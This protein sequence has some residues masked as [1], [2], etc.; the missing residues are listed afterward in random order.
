MVGGLIQL[1]AFGA[2]D[3]YLIGNP[4]ITYFKSVYSRHTN[5]CIESISHSHDGN[6]DFGNSINFSID[7]SG[8]LVGKSYIEIDI[9][10]NNQ[11]IDCIHRFGHAIIDKVE[12]EIG[13]Q[14]IDTHYGEWLEIWSQMSSTDSQL[15]TLRKMICGGIKSDVNIYKLYIPLQFWFNRNPGLALP[16]IALQYHKVKIN[17]TFKSRNKLNLHD[18]LIIQDI[19]LYCDYIYLDT[20]ER[21]R[22]AQVNHEYLIEQVQLNRHSLDANNDKVNIPLILNHPCKELIWIIKPNITINNYKIGVNNVSG[23]FNTDDTGVNQNTI[24][25]SNTNILN[26][27]NNSTTINLQKSDIHQNNF[28]AIT[29]GNY[30]NTPFLFCNYF[31][32]K[33]INSPSQYENDPYFEDI[34]KYA[35][36]K[37][38]NRDRFA[39]RHST[40]FRCV[41]PFQHHTGSH[42]QGGLSSVLK[43]GNN[44]Y[45]EDGYIYSYSFAIKPEEHFPTGTLNF[46]RIDNVTL[47]LD[48]NNKEYG[49]IAPNQVSFKVN[50]S[51]SIYAINY[52][53]LRIM[54][55]MGG[56]AYSN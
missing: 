38:N 19:S 25:L 51:I 28:V 7:R 20:D 48:L 22:F 37:L 17:V 34:L 1:V 40:Y 39:K 11:I 23:G 54:S 42:N 2:Q 32:G 49:G 24:V 15:N 47:E 27:S 4:Q 36:L 46:S 12:V 18:D 13:G 26:N 10:S 33:G 14:I 53:I 44:S 16:L 45:G 29:N 55:G 50:K 9:K 3:I 5:F 8:D 6:L 43:N 35:K 30:V 52:N 31:I 56:L 21:R 41:Q